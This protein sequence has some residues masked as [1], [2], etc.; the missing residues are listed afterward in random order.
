MA[1]RKL[2]WNSKNIQLLPEKQ[3]RRNRGNKQK[4]KNK[5]EDSSKA[6]QE[7]H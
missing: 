5:M 4:A 7:L 1:N 2:K 6:Y 3:E